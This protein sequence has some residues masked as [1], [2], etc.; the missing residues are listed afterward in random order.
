MAHSAL[1]AQGLAQLGRVVSDILTLMRMILHEGPRDEYHC[2]PLDL[3]FVDWTMR[4]IDSKLVTE[5]AQTMRDLTAA[6]AAEPD[7]GD[8]CFVSSLA[9]LAK[10]RE[11]CANIQARYC[12]CC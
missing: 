7:P 9:E 4:L 11:E 10:I 6:G 12:Y 5:A 2:R 8:N 3:E 1:N